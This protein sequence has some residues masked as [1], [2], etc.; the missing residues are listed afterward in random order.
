MRL[1]GG[2][3]AALSFKNISQSFVSASK[4]D[5]PALEGVS[6]D[7]P[8]G[9]F[10]AI[11]GPSGCGKST[12]LNLAAG[13]QAP[14]GGSIDVFGQ[15]LQGVNR[16]AG[17]LFQQ[18]ALLPWK[19]VM[20]NVALGLLLRGV[21]RG[22]AHDKASGW[23]HRVGLNGFEDSFP[24][25][26]SGGM[27]KRAALAQ[28]LIVDPEII[29]MD[30]PFSALDIHTRLRMESEVLSL[31]SGTAKTAAAAK[32]IVFVTHDLEEAIAM[33]DEVAVLSAGPRSRIT[34]RFDVTLPR[35][36][37]LIDIKLDPDF[38]EIYRAIWTTLREE[39][40]KSHLLAGTHR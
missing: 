12:L 27:R 34:G 9:R 37:N 30:E 6:L 26:L 28:T 24:F 39:V 3:A 40:L 38:Q 7:V 25:Q 33:A 14:S 32:T 36:R 19:N 15:P 21:A 31:W 18:D 1:A 5:Y 8:K 23:I 22:E 17:Y 20:D 29:L 11:A 10:V 35:P 2:P 16:H 4:G 13:L